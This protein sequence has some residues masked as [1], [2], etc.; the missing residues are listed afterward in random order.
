[1]A[2]PKAYSPREPPDHRELRRMESLLQRLNG[3]IMEQDLR[4]RELTK[5]M[6]TRTKREEVVLAAL[7]MDGESKRGEKGNLAKVDASIDHLQDYLLK[8]GDRIESI[9]QMLDTHRQ[10]MEKLG[11]KIQKG[12]DRGLMKME[13]D[14]M[15]NT[16]TILAM[17]GVEF[18]T[19]LV[20]DIDDLKRGLDNAKTKLADLKRRKLEVSRKFAEELK[21]FDLGTLYARRTK[22]PGYL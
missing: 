18:D 9:L 15:K 20:A 4:I 2:M 1:M 17:A 7:G 6:Q 19:G 14:I 8:M 21:R 12:E 22:I 10:F 16:L 5:D 13:L 3:R 11:Q